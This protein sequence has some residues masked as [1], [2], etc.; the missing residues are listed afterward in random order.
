MFKSTRASVAVAVLIG[1]ILIGSF[2]C[3]PDQQCGGAGWDSKNNFDLSLKIEIANVDL[4]FLLG[5]LSFLGK[6]EC[7][8]GEI[9]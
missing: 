5:I 8:K 1:A 6:R 9:W 7:D 2:D 4:W 3:K